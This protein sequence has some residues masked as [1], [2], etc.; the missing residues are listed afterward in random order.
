MEKELQEG[1]R[2]VER[3]ISMM[4]MTTAVLPYFIVALSLLLSDKLELG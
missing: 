3:E 2:T 4:L 1:N